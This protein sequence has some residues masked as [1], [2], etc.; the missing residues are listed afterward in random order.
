[1]A[2][3][4]PTELSANSPRRT[5]QFARNAQGGANTEM[6]TG[7]LQLVYA[8]PFTGM[9][10]EDPFAHL[11]KFYEIAG[12]TGVDAANEESLFKRLFPHSLIG[13]AKEWYLDQLP[14][15]MTDWN[16][17]EEKFLERYFP[18]SRFMEAKTAIAVFNQGSNESLNEAW[19]RFKSMLRKCKEDA[20]MIIDRMALND[21]Q[22][23]H[24]RS[25]SQRKPGVLELNTND[26]ILAQNKILSQQVELLT[27]QMSKLPQQMKE[28]HGMQMTSQVA[29]CELC[30]GDHPTGFC[31][32]PNGEE[33]NYVNNQNQGYQR[34][35]PPHNNPYQRNNQGFHPSRFSN[36][37]YQYQSPYQSSNPQG[38]GQQSQGG[39]SKLEDTLT[40][41]MQASMANQRSNEAA[42]KNLENQVGQLAK[43][44]SEQQPV[45]YFSANTQTNPKEHCKAIVTRSGKEVNSG[46]NEEVIVEDEEEVIVEDEEDEVIV[47]NEGEKSEERV[48]EE[49][50]EKEQEEKEEREKNDKKVKRNK[51]R[52][53]NMLTKKNKCTDKETVVLDAHCSAIIKK[54]L[55]RK[56]ADPGRVI[57]P[58]TIGGNYISN[59]L[60]DLGSSINLIPLSIVKRLGNIEMKH[61][62]I[63]LQL[64]DKSIISPYGVVQDMLVKVDK[65]L[66]P[67]DFVVVNMEEDRDVPLIL[68]RPFMKTTRMMIDIDDGIMKLR[69]QD[70][71]VIFTLFESMKPPKD[72][73][74][75]F[76][77]DDEKGEIIEVA[78][79]FHKD[80]EKANHEGKTHHQNFEVGQ[81]VLVCNSRLKVFS[82]KLKSKWSGPFVVKEV[83]NYGAIVVED[84]KTQ[85][86]W[87]VK[88]QRLKGYHDG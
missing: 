83:R 12:S 81:M 67:V 23:Q 77:I 73:H 56:E 43:Q 60:V 2:G 46:V 58:I 35:H 80:K 32:P 40:Q 26:A 76:R 66:F 55:P 64:A 75:N 10:H 62:R 22:T 5:A 74:D 44:L 69:V 27:K 41:F 88:E 14:N 82:S 49:I 6:K 47:E 71:E 3:V 57:L 87:T 21:L 11:T 78:N 52:N 20:I 48:E 65:F 24:D 36:Q 59:G 1:M 50:V 30:Q 13:K 54:T 38:Q 33:V 85:E 16:L 34:Q 39:S 29:S 53:E 61:T 28:I 51:K 15:V 17:L 7:I 19:E 86:S 68:G 63:T 70:K 4:V 79:Q 84:P 31:P 9:D 37:H 18:Q 72:E 45:A 25:P 42:I 8:N